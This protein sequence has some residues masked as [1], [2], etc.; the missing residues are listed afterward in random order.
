[1]GLNIF[2]KLTKIDTQEVFNTVASGVDKAFYTKEEQSDDARKVYQDY[3]EW[4]KTTLEESTVRSIT[5]RI[6]AIL[7]A[8]CYLLLVIASAIAYKFD[9]EYSS[10]LWEVS[11]AIAPVVG[12]IMLFYFGYYG[13]KNV[14]KEN[15]KK[16]R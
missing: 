4:Y 11:K 5:R 1:M 13:V 14:V 15:N 12:G 16:K 8:A 9:P 3:F 6:L 7:F 2:K 10:F